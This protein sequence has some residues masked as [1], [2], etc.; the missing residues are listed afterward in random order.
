MPW[1]KTKSQRTLVALTKYFYLILFLTILLVNLTICII[2]RVTNLVFNLFF[3]EK[4]EKTKKKVIT[5]ISVKTNP[6][7]VLHSKL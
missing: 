6:D 4:D 3:S 1:M 2:M 7:Q 5:R